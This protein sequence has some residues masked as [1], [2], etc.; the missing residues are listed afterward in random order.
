MGAR[1]L[2]QMSGKNNYQTPQSAHSN[3]ILPTQ[4]SATPQ[5]NGQGVMS[6]RNNKAIRN[7]PAPQGSGTVITTARKNPAATNTPITNTK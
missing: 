1:K 5:N 4:I 6:A 2:S 3:S 7:T